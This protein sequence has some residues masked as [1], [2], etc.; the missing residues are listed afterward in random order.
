MLIFVEIILR[1]IIM[2]IIMIIRTVI[3]IIE[4]KRQQQQQ[5]Q[6][7]QHQHQQQQQ[8]QQQ[9]NNN[10][11]KKNSNSNSDSNNSKWEEE[12]DWK[13]LGITSTNWKFRNM[14]DC[15]EQQKFGLELD[16]SR[17]QHLR[18]D[19]SIKNAALRIRLGLVVK[20]WSR[21]MPN[22]QRNDFDLEK[23]WSHK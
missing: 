12:G 5:Q 7:Q 13:R 10:K 17:F 16:R 22:K 14:K 4:I 3:V 6:Q 2:R 1:A 21:N 9:K 18:L 19:W 23:L 11:K 8:Q 20:L 15:F